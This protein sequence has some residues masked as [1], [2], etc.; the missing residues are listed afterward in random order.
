MLHVQASAFATLFK[1]T[2]IRDV[3]AIKTDG[4]A[5]AH[6]DSLAFHV[7]TISGPLKLKRNLFLLLPSFRL[8]FIIFN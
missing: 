1:Q 3:S 8:Y 4:E 7:E 5:A 2:V 6:S